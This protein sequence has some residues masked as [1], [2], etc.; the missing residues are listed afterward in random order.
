[1]FG[2]TKESCGEYMLESEEHGPE[3]PAHCVWWFPYLECSVWSSGVGSL[4]ATCV[5][6]PPRSVIWTDRAGESV[7][8]GGVM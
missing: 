3:S 7:T 5:K 6:G 2:R 1:M 4:N 8:A